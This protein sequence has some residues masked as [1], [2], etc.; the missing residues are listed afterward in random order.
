MCPVLPLTLLSPSL[1]ASR[2][3][4]LTNFS[5]AATCSEDPSSVVD[6]YRRVANHVYN[7]HNTST[8]QE[9]V[10]KIE[11]K[12][13]QASVVTVMR[14]MQLPD[15]YTVLCSPWHIA[16]NDMI[17]NSLGGMS[18]I[19]PNPRESDKISIKDLGILSNLFQAVVVGEADSVMQPLK[20]KTA[21]KSPITILK[22]S[23]KFDDADL[24]WISSK[25]ITHEST[26]YCMWYLSCPF[27]HVLFSSTDCEV[28]LK[29]G[30]S[31]PLKTWKP[32]YDVPENTPICANTQHRV[33]TNALMKVYNFL[34]RLQN[35]LPEMH[36]VT[37]LPIFPTNVI[38]YDCIGMNTHKVM[39]SMHK[40]FP[41]VYFSSQ[42]C[43]TVL[44][45]IMD[46]F[47]NGWL[48]I[49]KKLRFGHSLRFDSRYFR[50]IRA[51][52]YDEAHSNMT[53]TLPFLMDQWLETVN[54][55]FADHAVYITGLYLLYH[56]C[57]ASQII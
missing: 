56:L 17:T 36:Y 54:S 11:K 20:Y 30:C 48:E 33:A 35:V 27:P 50:N 44:T 4:H 28:C 43:A 26:N 3:S 25:A 21:N 24:E 31:R 52:N 53:S 14:E 47:K 40:E 1:P 42:P 8:I 5:H 16:I 9:N 19:F 6:A 49:F 18:A 39:H 51:L 38:S 57:Y 34:F 22:R 55:I 10:H 29:E 32:S 46:I 15:Q 13:L 7:F 41:Q 37:V 23:L 45:P 12:V 2:R